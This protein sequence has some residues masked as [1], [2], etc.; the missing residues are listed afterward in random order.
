M[1]ALTF[2]IHAEEPLLIPQLEGDPNSAVSYTFIPGSVIR[3]AL[4]NQHLAGAK[5]D[6]SED[7]QE[8]AFFFNG[9]V[10]YLNAYPLDRQGRRTL[11]APVAWFQ[12]KDSRGETGEV[13]YDFSVEPALYLDQPKTVGERFCQLFLADADEEEYDR[14]KT[15]TVEFTM[16]QPHISIHTARDRKK[17][18][19]T[20][21]EGAVFRYQALA[22]GEKF[23]GV[24]LAPDGQDLSPLRKLLEAGE[25]WLGGSRS[26]GYGRVRIKEIKTVESWSE[27]G[28]AIEDV[29]AGDRV[30]ITCLSDLMIRHTSGTRAGSYA[31][32]LSPGLLPEP[33]KTALKPAAEGI[34]RRVRTLGGFNSKWGL[35][36]YQ[37]QTI[38]AGSVFVFEALAPLSAT[39][40]ASLAAA[41]I[42]ERRVEGFGRIGVNWHSQSSEL[43][44][45]KVDRQ[46]EAGP[47]V[48]L[49][50][51]SQ[52]LAG[53][54]ASRLLEREL[55][56]AVAD[57]ISGRSFGER[58]WPSK[59]QL[60]R[61]RT[62]ALNALPGGD[63]ERLQEFLS[64]KKLKATAREQY[65]QARIDGVRLLD[66]LRTCLE[67]GTSRPEALLERL[68]GTRAIQLPRIG[69]VR[70]EMTDKLAR[71]Y[72]IRLIEG[73]LHRA[74]KEARS[75]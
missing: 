47:P 19:A 25:L 28:S 9:A 12:E 7:Q 32:R 16:P 26:G 66:W 17:G 24:I 51:N 1:I 6:L 8:Q 31:D 64:D 57:Y 20:A 33:F 67:E 63:L 61:L 58:A 55:E 18:R 34:Y 59:A 46:R 22:D 44:L 62:I 15:P 21:D 69:P 75:E 71:R 54:M 49:S 56:K 72:T 29:A 73:L 48:S 23:G 43:S 52:D 27:T 38:Q 37:V 5:L 50:K 3:G 13:I 74:A 42:G 40:L 36:L 41:G 2:E 35:P 10:R 65:R 70:A 68:G 4:V 11:P 53:E 14:S 39:D 30:T 60:S 45:R